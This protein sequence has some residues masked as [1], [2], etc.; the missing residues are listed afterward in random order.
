MTKAEMIAEVARHT[1]SSPTLAARALDNLFEGIVAS[2]LKGNAVRLPAI[3]VLSLKKT[4]ARAVRNPLTGA[5][6]PDKPAGHK[7]ALKAGQELR[8]RLGL[9]PA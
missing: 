6:L 4:A 3:G 7:V 9:L 2:V 1:G 5:A 8:S